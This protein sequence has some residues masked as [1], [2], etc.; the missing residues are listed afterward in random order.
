MFTQNTKDFKGNG[1][2]GD[3]NQGT[4]YVDVTMAQDQPGTIISTPLKDWGYLGTKR[5]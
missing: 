2:P 5:G 4:H 1:F 3:F